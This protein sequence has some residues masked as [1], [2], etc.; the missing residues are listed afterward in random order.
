MLQPLLP[1]MHRI[2]IAR[3]AIIDAQANLLQVEHSNTEAL[4][5]LFDVT[6]VTGDAAHQLFQAF[7]PLAKIITR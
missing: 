3:S 4:L 7:Q 2:A 1:P 5:L 6:E